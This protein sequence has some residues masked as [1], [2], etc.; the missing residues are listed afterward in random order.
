[1][2][3][4]STHQLLILSRHADSYR[5]HVEAA[6]LP[7]LEI[8][9]AADIA[10]LPDAARRSDLVFGEPSL[11]AQVLPQ[12][13]A[14]R[15]IQAT[16]AGVEPL[17]NPALRRDYELTNA[18]GVFGVLMCEYVF[19]YLLAY[20]RKVVEK[21]ES[22]KLCRWDARAPGTLRGKTVGL[23]GVGTIGAALARTAKHFGMAVKGY[24]RASR[25]CP[26]VDAYFHAGEEARFAAD[27]D[28]VVCIVP[29]TAGTRR[30]IGRA[31]LAALPPRA[32][33][34]NPGRGSVID[35]DALRDALSQGRLAAAVLDVFETEPLPPD[36]PL[37]RMPNVF[38]TSHTAALSLP[39]DIAPLFIDNYRRLVTG[40][41]LKYRVDFN[42]EY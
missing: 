19:G 37:W 3:T 14:V 38:V 42:L 22:Q 41:P 9:S 20:E 13:P 4:T 7:D 12:L 25:D 29:N 30:L 11:I 39:A 36:D 16:W 31:F 33:I 10:S 35:H 1:M 5:R 26:E 15:W 23:L 8:V 18:R 28:Y 34:V 24:T 2:A 17:L 27:L 6:A 21:Y 32:V 40:Q